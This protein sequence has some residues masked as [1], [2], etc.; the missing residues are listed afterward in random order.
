MPQ[1]A[2]SPRKWQ[3]EVEFSWFAGTAAAVHL[4][5]VQFHRSSILLLAAL[6]LAVSA[7]PAQ[8]TILPR[9][10]DATRTGTAPVIDGRL[11][12]PA[13]RSAS[14]SEPFVDI[15]GELRPTPRYLTRVKLAWD[16]TFLYIGADLEE[17]DLWGTINTRDAVIF[18]DN[19]FE[20][21]LDPDGNRRNYFELEINALGTVWDLFLARTYRDGG[22]ADNGWDIAGLRSAVLLHGTLNDPSDRDMGWSLELALPWQSLAP[23]GQTGRPP[24]S[25]DSWRVN[26]S[27]VEWNL[28]AA[29]GGGYTKQTDPATGKPQAEMNW[30]WS[31]QGVI[32]MHRPERWGVV[33]FVEDGN[34]EMVR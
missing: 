5:G 6:A 7:A 1:I 13:W 27:R 21:F 15:E 23:P 24:H 16:S 4:W 10:Y 28:V 29:A 20:V 32:D 3:D 2:P 14:W 22:Q 19:D 30:V 33:R 26:F 11:D 9:E 12:D 18:Q 8:T 25:G 31:P 34:G 17:P